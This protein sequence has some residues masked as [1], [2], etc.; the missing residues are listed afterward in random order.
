MSKR[1]LGCRCGAA[2]IDVGDNSHY[3]R[4]VKIFTKLAL[5]GMGAAKLQRAVELINPHLYTVEERIRE[6]A[7]AFDP[8][9]EG[10]F[11][12]AC[13]GGGKRLR[14]ILTLLSGAATGI[15]CTSH[16]DLAVIVELIHLATLVHDDIMDGA[17]I[18]RDQATVN[19]KWGNTLSV[20][21]G[22]CL[23]AH[24][25]QLAAAFPNN[26]ICRRIAHAAKEVC[27]GEIIQTQRRFDLNLTIAEYFR[28][29]EM[30]TAA[31]F[32]VAAE[33]GAFISEASPEVITAMKAYGL[34]LGTAYQIYDDCLDIAGTEEKAGK[35]LGS[36]LRKGKLTLPVLYLLQMVEPE[37]HHRFSE[38]LLR[39]NEDE[40]DSLG[41]EVV[42]RG[43][44]RRAVDTTKQLVVEAQSELLRLPVNKYSLAMQDIGDFLSNIV[45]QFA[46]AA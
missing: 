18:R 15:V 44:L 5:Q 1:E 16:I 26:A 21:L 22:D 30:K 40:L 37:E 25:L 36:D 45:D 38:V 29:I 32:A 23:F 12:Y 7:R 34:K 3:D 20:L 19:A 41:E 28:V 13:G 4:L 39:A 43:A 24:A 10:Y 6:Q 46:V 27:S 33:L 11:Q 14:P 9:I 2:K 17:D 8:A 35:S 42:R 31:L